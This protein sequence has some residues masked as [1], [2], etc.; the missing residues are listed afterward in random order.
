MLDRSRHGE[1]GDAYQQT[2]ADADDHQR[3]DQS[4]RATGC[5][6]RAQAEPHRADHEPVDDRVPR[7]AAGHVDA[8]AGDGS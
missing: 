7:A 1:Q 8:R 5:V 3:R 2:R 4:E 6:S